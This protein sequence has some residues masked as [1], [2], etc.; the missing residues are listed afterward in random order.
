[1][2]APAHVSYSALTSW[3]SCGEKYRL[4]RV[5]GLAEGESWWLTGGKAVH[6]TTEAFDH[7]LISPD[8]AEPFQSRE[9]FAAALAR[10]A[11]DDPDT[12]RS[13]RGQTGEWWAEHGPDMVD[14]WVDW[15]AETDWSIW[16]DPATGA[17]GIELDVSTEIDGLTVKAYIDRVF[18]DGDGQVIIVDI[19]SGSRAPSSALQLGVYAALLE[20][21]YGVRASLG[22]YFMARKGTLTTPVP[23]DKYDADYIGRFMTGFDSARKAGVYL[24][25]PDSWCST[26][27]VADR[28]WLNT[29][30][31]P[32]NGT[33]AS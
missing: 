26:C 18:V 28:C 25:N 13:S 27:G 32:F 14:K 8:P 20:A 9:T 24:P 31:V 10:N 3:L 33:K 30:G 22:A 19:K 16:M 1:M 12:A 2:S 29:G 4:T 23:L 5:L 6:E 17:T 7:W 21:R 11:P 15:R